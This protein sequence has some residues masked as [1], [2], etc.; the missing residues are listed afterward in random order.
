MTISRLLYKR[1]REEA[2]RSSEWR[3]VL[4]HLDE[5]LQNLKDA[6]KKKFDK[7]PSQSF[8]EESRSDFIP[9]LLEFYEQFHDIQPHIEAA[10]TRAL[11]L[12]FGN[13]EVSQWAILKASALFSSYPKK[14]VSNMVWWLAGKQYMRIKADAG[15][16]A[17]HSVT[18][19]MYIIQKPDATLIRRMRVEGHEDLSEECA[20]VANVDDLDALEDD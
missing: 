17:S 16:G 3:E 15:P 20:S 7:K 5:D 14:Y 2:A 18:P 1:Y 11:L 6:W 9:L 12:G 10:H 8:N 19:G 4:D 13:P